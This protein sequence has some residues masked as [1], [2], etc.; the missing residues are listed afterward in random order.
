[1]SP[2]TTSPKTWRDIRT[3]LA[4]LGAKPQRVK[5]S[6]E[7]WRFDDGASFVVVRNHLG[8]DAPAYVLVNLRRLRDGRFVRE[9]ASPPPRER[10]RGAAA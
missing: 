9:E 7:V 10:L 8:R 5:G 2:R 4:R 1:M 6:H 3:E